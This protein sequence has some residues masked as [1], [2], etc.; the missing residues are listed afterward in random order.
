MSFSRESVKT[1]IS[2]NTLNSVFFSDENINIIQQ[3]IIEEI[4]RNHNYTI[5]KQSPI[6][7][8][9]IMRSV[10]LQYGKNLNDEIKSQVAELNRLVID[11]CVPNIVS[12]IKQYLRFRKDNASL[13]VPLAHPKSMSS[14]GTKT[15][16]MSQII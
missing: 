16:T 10:Y 3:N 13:P 8:K 12:N 9:I 14:A 7:L 11:E 4:K 15:L 5:Q 2:C 6:E 1:V